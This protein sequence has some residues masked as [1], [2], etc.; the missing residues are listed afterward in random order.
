MVVANLDVANDKPMSQNGFADL[1]A[2]VEGTYECL[3][4]TCEDI[5]TYQTSAGPYPGMESCAGPSDADGGAG[6]AL[7][8]IAG[9]LPAT[10]VVPHSMIDLDQ[11]EISSAAGEGTDAGFDEAIRVYQQGG[12]GT[13][14][15]S[16]VA[17]E[18]IN[19]CNAV[20]DPKGNSVKGSGAIRTIEGFA[21]SG[22]TKMME[23]PT[24]ITYKDYWGDEKYCDTFV[25]SAYNSPTM[26]AYQKIELI[27]KGT[28]Y[29][30]VWMYV[31]HEFED[32]IADCRAGD[33]YDNDKTPTGAAPHAWDEGVAF[34]AGSLEGETG[35]SSGQ[36]LHNLAQKRCGR[37]G[38]CAAD[39]MAEANVEIYKLFNQGRDEIQAEKCDD[40]AETLN[41]I[42]PL[43]TLPL[44]QGTVEYAYKSDPKSAYD[45]KHQAEGDRDCLKEWA[46]GW[47]FAAAALPQI[48]KCDADAAQVVRNNL[49]VPSEGGKAGDQVPDG[50]MKVKEAVE[51]TY[52]CLG[53]TCEQVGVFDAANSGMEACTGTGGGG[54]GGGGGSGGDGGD[55][56]NSSDAALGLR[57][58]LLAA[59]AALAAYAL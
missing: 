39:T 20:G 9:Y 36:L 18:A 4:L 50:Y 23:E 54:G 45:C 31:L 53:I 5:G 38:T 12:G 2:A 34:Y 42:I 24:Y 29:Q 6:G 44:I 35:G 30:C 32:A 19:Q 33:I 14:T 48:A 17:D 1:K 21:T 7:A 28:P 47:A 56:D 10:D 15:A 58:S 51:S 22:P 49:E 52:E 40:A 43:M 25:M 55:G 13:C 46:E 26:D 3:G 57:A 8:P 16:D 27:K 37:M 41:K 59:L 11:Q